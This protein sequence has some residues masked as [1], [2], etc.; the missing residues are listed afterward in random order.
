L[1]ILYDITTLAHIHGAPAGQRAG[2]FRHTEEMCVALASALGGDFYLSV[3]APQYE[4]AIRYLTETERL[5]LDRFPLPSFGAQEITASALTSKRAWTPGGASLGPAFDRYLALVYSPERIYNA[6]L[7]DVYHVNWRGVTTLPDRAHPTVLVTVPDVIAVKHPEWFVHPGAPNPLGEYQATVLQSVRGHHAVNVST[8][9]VKRDVL[10]LFPHI[11][12]E[13]VHVVPL[14][15]S[16]RFGPCDGQDR[17]DAVRTRYGIPAGH[18]YLLCVNTLEPRKNMTT[19]IDAFAALVGDGAAE[20]VSLVLAGSTGWLGDDLVERCRRVAG[21]EAPVVVTGYVDD[22][23]LAPLY[24][25]A[26]LFCYPSLDEGFGLPVL[27]AMKCGVPVI[28]SDRPPLVEAADDAGLAVDPRDTA[29]LAEAMRRI[30]H[31]RD[32]ADDLRAR[33]RARAATYTWDRSAA[34]M[35]EAYARA[36]AHRD[37]RG[38]LGAGRRWV[39]AGRRSTNGDVPRRPR[40]VPIGARSLDELAGAFQGER[41][42]ILGSGFDPDCEP[43]ALVGDEYTIAINQFHR[44]YDRIPWKPSFYTVAAGGADRDRALELNAVTGSTFLF[45]EQL[46]DALR[47]GPDVVQYGFEDGTSRVVGVD[48]FNSTAAPDIRGPD[49]SLAAAIQVAFHL[50]F[51]PIYLV[52]CAG[53]SMRAWHVACR[54]A[55]DAAGRQIRNLSPNT[56]SDVYRRSDRHLVFAAGQLPEFGRDRHAH[57]DE[58]AVIATMFDARDGRTR[59]MIDVGAARGTSARHFV[60]RGWKVHC[61]EPDA[62]DREHLTRRFGARTTVIIDPRA[63]AAEPDSATLGAIVDERSIRHLDVLRIGVAGLGVDVLKGLPWDRIEPDVIQCQY[64][65]ASAD[66]RRNTVGDVAEYL[67]ARGYAVYVSEWHPMSG[68]GFAHDWRRVGHY[69]GLDV[70]PNSWGNVLAFKDDPGYAVVQNAFAGCIT[71][72]AEHLHQPPVPSTKTPP[73]TTVALGTAPKRP[74][75][76]DLPMAAR[77]K[78]RFYA[79]ATDRLRARAP[80]FYGVARLARRALANTLR[81]RRIAFVVGGA[82]VAAVVAAGFALSG[83]W[84]LLLWTGAAAALCIAALLAV[85]MYSYRIAV[86]QDTL[87]RRVRD[88]EH[89]VVAESRRSAARVQSLEGRIERMSRLPHELSV[90]RR[91][92]QQDANRIADLQDRLLDGESKHS[93]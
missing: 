14:G 45:D 83:A 25:G 48:L 87:A 54:V 86:R 57:V 76:A 8:E 61:F 22:A 46:S 34:M 65:G 11:D 89:R 31:D 53:E 80:E 78:R 24:A 91:Q 19:V 69:A 63:V 81:R 55:C 29:G 73:S 93:S 16:N 38:R 66:P 28:T 59:T 9:S 15:V 64:D 50:G 51:E 88:L 30:L 41:V 7:F 12:H 85:A 17:I 60:S 21:R 70:P 72:H 49:R 5:G 43:V 52:G 36:C 67:R 6:G 84:R 1:R 44:H 4:N 75:D 27:E 10:E 74:S 37:D 13:Q 35:V 33:G 18:R 71:T 39:A 2:I 20:G 40:T 32:L 3:A 56:L 62:A 79:D 92:Q 68:D 82:A 23:D 47:A 90:L 58:S 26:S 42:F 77:P